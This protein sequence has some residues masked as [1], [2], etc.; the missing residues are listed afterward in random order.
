MTTDRTAAAQGPVD[1]HA[2]SGSDERPPRQLDGGIVAGL[3]AE[4]ERLTGLPGDGTRT[5]RATTL[6]A[7]DHLRIT[8]VRLDEAGQIG[9]AGTDGDEVAVQ[10]LDGQVTILAG[11][12][13]TALEAGE[14]AGIRRGGPWT[15]RAVGPATVLL[16]VGLSCEDG[17]A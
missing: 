10:V 4:A 1:D 5:A 14:L 11:G 12:R 3:E 6:V 7:G 17:G 15:V 8:L 13:E 9:N 2:T 16:S